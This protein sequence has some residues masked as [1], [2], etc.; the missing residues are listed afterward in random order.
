[1]RYPDNF[2]WGAATSALQIEGAASSDGRGCSVWDDFCRRHPERIFQRATPEVACDHYHRFQEDVDLIADMG[3]NSY[4]FSI[5]WPRLLPEGRGRL[6]SAGLDFYDRLLDALKAKNITTVTTLYHWDLPL[7]LGSWEDL[8][9]VEAFVEYARL[10]FERFGDRVDYWC[11]L[12]EPGWSILNGYVTALHPPARQ[13]LKAAV[14]V[15]HHMMIAHRQVCREASGQ[16]G[17]ALNLSPVYSATARADDLAA[18]RRADGVLNR[19]FVEA[20]VQGRYP[21]D[22]VELYDRLGYLPEGYD[23]LPEARLD[24][25]GVNYYYPHYAVDA[26]MGPGAV[27]S[28]NDFHLNTSGDKAE[29]CRFTLSGCFTFVANPRGRYTDWA[30][31]IDPETLERL[32]LELSQSYPGLPLLVTENGIG[33]PDSAGDG[34]LDDHERIE[35]VAAHLKAVGRAME[36]GADVRGYFMWSLM[37]NFSWV[38]GYKKRYGFLHIDPQTLRRTPRASARWFAGVAARGELD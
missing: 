36:R 17:I 31:E 15:S 2:L 9:T 4:R 29:A 34:R 14:L 32:L 1:M 21:E 16:V 25:L 23:R 27:G 30:W 37:D 3:H 28:G 7:A 20:A 13:N 10:C 12:N 6:N 24:F 33:L 11:T 5:S 18:A 35:F 26:P 19:W 8:A 22:V 38:N